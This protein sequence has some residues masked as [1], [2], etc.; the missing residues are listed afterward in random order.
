M[1]DPETRK[2]RKS[3][4]KFEGHVPVVGPYAEYL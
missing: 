2:L 4:A 1:E 3:C